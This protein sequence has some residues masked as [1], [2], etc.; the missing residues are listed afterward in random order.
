MRPSRSNRIALPILPAGSS[1]NSSDSAAPGRSLPMVPCLRKFT[2]Y[3]T[4]AAST[5]GPS[6]PKVYSACG[7]TCRLANSAS[8]S[9]PSAARV[10]APASAILNRTKLLHRNV[11]AVAIEAFAVQIHIGRAE[12]SAE[13]RLL[14]RTFVDHD[15][16]GVV[17]D[18]TTIGFIA[19]G[20]PL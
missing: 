4:P 2:T 10:S 11:I 7:V 12:N 14:S 3:K 13:A 15:N 19:A 20:D 17:R 5:A 6:M 9:A 8:P 18:R 1:V 16:K